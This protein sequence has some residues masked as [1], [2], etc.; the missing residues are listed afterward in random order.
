MEELL[1]RLRASIKPLGKDAQGEQIDQ[2][3]EYVHLPLT[4]N[5]RADFSLVVSSTCA[6]LI[7]LFLT[8]DNL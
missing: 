7:Q 4:K 5:D 1:T 8:A 6:L 3:R 2:L